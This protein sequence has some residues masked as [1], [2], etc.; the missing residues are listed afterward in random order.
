MPGKR[1]LIHW[2]SAEAGGRAG[3]RIWEDA[4]GVA[5]IYLTRLPSRGRE[6]TDYLRSTKATRDVPV[7]FV[8][9][10][11]AALDMTRAKA[12]DSVFTTAA[13]LNDVLAKIRNMH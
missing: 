4:P 13:R 5:V 3:K 11:D 10:E 6:T 1:F 7:V 12:P 8:D 9:G 2:N